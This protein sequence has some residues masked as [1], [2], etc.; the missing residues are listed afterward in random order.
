MKCVISRFDARNIREHS[1]IIN[2][3]YSSRQRFHSEDMMRRSRHDPQS[4]VI[5]N[6]AFPGIFFTRDV[7]AG[8]LIQ[9]PSGQPKI[10]G[11]LRSLFVDNPM[12]DESRVY[13]SGYTVGV[14]SQGHSGTAYDKY[15]GDD[16]TAGEALSQSSES[17]FKFRPAE[18]DIVSFVHAAARSRAD[19]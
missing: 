19:R 10:I 18:K 8:L 13:V 15:V 6:A 2:I 16:T 11:D 5:E 17:T 7:D 4:R 14:I 9:P 1:K 12:R 3:T